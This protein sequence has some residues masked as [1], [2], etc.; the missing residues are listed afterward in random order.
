[1]DNYFQSV[2]IE[3][4]QPIVDGGRYPIKREEGDSV[5]V[6]ADIFK[7]GH[8]VI[9]A[10]LRYRKRVPVTGPTSPWIT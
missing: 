3:Q 10:F 5:S 4:V 1:M 8:D 7:D 9:V 2:V 6:S